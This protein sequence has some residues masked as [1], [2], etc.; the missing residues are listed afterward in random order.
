MGKS[1]VVNALGAHFIKKHG[2][3]VF[4]AKPEENNKKT[5]KLVLGKIVGKFFHD[6]K[7]PF[8]MDAYEEAG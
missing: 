2:L 7:K 3:N 6:P 8:D 5:Y 1:E 4:M